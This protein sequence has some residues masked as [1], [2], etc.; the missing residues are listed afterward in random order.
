M[1]FSAAVVPEISKQEDCFYFILFLCNSWDTLSRQ[2][3]LAFTS[4]RLRSY[5][6]YTYHAISIL[7]EVFA[8]HPD[9]QHLIRDWRNARALDFFFLPRFPCFGW[10]DYG[11][12]MLQYHQAP[13]AAKLMCGHAE[14]L[15]DPYESRRM[16]RASRTLYA[17]TAASQ[18]REVRDVRGR[19][20]K[21]FGCNGWSFSI[22]TTMR[23]SVACWLMQEV[24]CTSK[25]CN[26]GYCVR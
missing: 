26:A 21:G 16:A 2:N 11:L 20:G 1:G 6:L 8:V 10:L 24:E 18:A 14:D 15:K 23:T 17:G 4:T 12:I 22:P 7:D 9:D 19:R 25:Y 5:I 3:L 13:T